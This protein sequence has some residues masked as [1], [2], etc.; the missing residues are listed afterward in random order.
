MSVLTDGFK[1]APLL[2]E[3]LEE[4]Q[5]ACDYLDRTRIAAT[6]IDDL[7]DE[8]Y[9]KFT[10]QRLEIDVDEIRLLRTQDEMTGLMQPDGEVVAFPQIMQ[11]LRLPYT[12]D[13]QLWR[14]VPSRSH[15]GDALNMVEVGGPDYLLLHFDAS[16]KDQ[17]QLTAER[18]ALVRNL[19]QAVDWCNLDVD[20]W[21]TSLRV[22][23]KRRLESRLQ[24][25]EQARSLDQSS[26]IPIYRAPIE[27]QIP[28]PVERVTLRP[29][30]S[31]TPIASDPVMAQE[32]YDD[33]VQTIE[34]M[35]RAMERTPTAAK[36]KEEEI[37]DLILFVLNANYRGAAAGEV[38][39]GVGRN[40][41]L[42]RWDDANAFIG[43]CKFWTG[44]SDF[45][46]AIDQL[47]S[48]VTW[49]DTKAALIVFIRNGKPDDV[50][51]KAHA[52]M[53]AHASYKS[54]APETTSDLR[55]NYVLCS[56][57]DDERL[58]SVALIGV[59]IQPAKS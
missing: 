41:I 25:I 58:I 42:L 44:P 37:R 43:E 54:G 23:I 16:G 27:E 11:A 59:V 35:T 22:Q 7:T 33:V 51:K 36:L 53:C 57:L 8:L 18:E 50:M 45:R 21:N 4:A 24:R 52:E 17:P 12:G 34:Q 29:T 40:D 3:R 10:L 9:A 49:R 56:K 1:L 14:S 6:H 28:I 32:I 20:P 26:D 19:Q 55:A 31:G 38:F 2:A 48:Y 13:R 15:R 46:A 30:P 39:N 5:R 47:L